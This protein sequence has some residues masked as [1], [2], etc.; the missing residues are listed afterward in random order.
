MRE[1]LYQALASDR[2]IVLETDEP[3]RV[4]AKLHAA[5]REAKDPDLK[6]LVIA[7]SREKPES[8]VFIAKKEQTV[9]PQE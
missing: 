9:A 5:R 8:E 3:D 1:F 2:G 6:V 7:K 4:I